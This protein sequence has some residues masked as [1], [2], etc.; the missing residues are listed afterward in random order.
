MVLLLILSNP[1]STIFWKIY[2]CV[3]YPLVLH[4]S[5]TCARKHIVN[6]T[7]QPLNLDMQVVS[8]RYEYAEQLHFYMLID[9]CLIL[10]FYPSVEWY[11]GLR[12]C[13]TVLVGLLKKIPDY[14]KVINMNILKKCVKKIK[15]FKFFKVFFFIC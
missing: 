3:F 8:T 10:E 13:L 7:L 6:S 4:V 9:F 1:I 2:H 12:R 15:V 11:D 14:M 5:I